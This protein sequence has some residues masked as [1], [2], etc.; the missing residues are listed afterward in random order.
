MEDIIDVIV[1]TAEPAVDA[2]K[3]WCGDAIQNA[4]SHAPQ[5]ASI[6]IKALRS[7]L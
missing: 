2:V 4:I 7:I 6:A 1:E 5:Y 3:D